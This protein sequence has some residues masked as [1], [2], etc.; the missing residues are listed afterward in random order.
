MKQELEQN[1]DIEF[2]R[3]ILEWATNEETDLGVL[4]ELRWKFIEVLEYRQAKAKI[5]NGN[6]IKDWIDELV[7]SIVQKSKK[8]NNE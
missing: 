5:R 8:S 1:K 6:D 7:S 3:K 2:S 4:I